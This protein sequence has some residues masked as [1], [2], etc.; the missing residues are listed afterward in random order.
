MRRTTL[1]LLG[2]GV[3]VS[4]ALT[5][6]GANEAPSS[7]GGSTASGQ[8]SSSGAKVGVILPE[9]ATS[10]RWEG[11][12]RPA[13]AEAMKAE[14][15]EADIQNA[16]GDVQKFSQLADTMISS[17]VKVL[18]IGSINSEVGASVAAKAK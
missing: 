13:I 15:L 16:Q 5:A 1:A 6:C 3:G 10:A 11:F 18:V 7:G 12:D 8:P 2:A 14:G 17:G 9:T 4:L